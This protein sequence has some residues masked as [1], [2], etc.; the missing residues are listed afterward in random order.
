MFI[1]T[2]LLA[3]APTDTEL[4]EARTFVVAQDAG[5]DF[6]QLIDEVISHIKVDAG[7]NQ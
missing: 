6:S 5:I 7:R 2:N 1:F 3:L 4:E